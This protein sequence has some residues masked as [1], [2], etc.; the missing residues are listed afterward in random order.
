VQ[1]YHFYRPMPVPDFEKLIG[2]EGNIDTGG[3]VL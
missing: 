2:D 1:G 3:F